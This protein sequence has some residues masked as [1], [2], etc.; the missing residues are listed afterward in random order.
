MNPYTGRLTRL[1]DDEA[2][3]LYDGVN[4]RMIPVPEELQPE[5]EKALG[6]LKETV[7]NLKAKSPLAD[8]AAAQRKQNSRKKM[9]KASRRRNRR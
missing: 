7:I 2:K 5:A 8:F 3:E 6:G 1:T 9:Q 4:W